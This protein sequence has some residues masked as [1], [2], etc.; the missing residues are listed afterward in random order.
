MAASPT[1]EQKLRFRFWVEFSAA[2]RGLRTAQAGANGAIGPG[3]RRVVWYFVDTLDEIE[4]CVDEDFWPLDERK[5]FERA[6]QRAEQYHDPRILWTE[7][8]TYRPERRARKPER[9]RELAAARL[10]V[11]DALVRNCG[12]QQQGKADAVTALA[13]MAAQAYRDRLNLDAQ[14][15]DPAMPETAI[16]EKAVDLLARAQDVLDHLDRDRNY[17]GVVAKAAPPSPLW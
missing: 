1:E 4:V 10:A 2:D 11:A 17:V 16:A 6:Q 3:F 7:A 9:G 15:T 8:K 5:A 13:E 14:S 12:V